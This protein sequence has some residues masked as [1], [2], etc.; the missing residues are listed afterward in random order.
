M[1]TST[2]ISIDKFAQAPFDSQIRVEAP[3]TEVFVSSGAFTLKNLSDNADIKLE[4]G[5]GEEIYSK[6][7][8]EML[9]KVVSNG[10][11]DLDRSSTSARPH[12]NLGL[13]LMNRGMLPEAEREL[14]EALKKDPKYFVAGMALARIRAIGGDFDGA[15]RL[16]DRLSKEH[17]DKAMPKMGLAYIAMQR[18]NFQEAEQ[19]LRAVVETDRQNIWAKYHLGLVL[20]KLE[21]SQ[22]AIALLRDAAR[23]GVRLPAIHHALGVAYAQKKDFKKAIRSFSMALSLA[24]RMRETIHAFSDVLLHLK[25]GE[26][27]IS[28]LR[29]FVE[30]EG[31]EVLET[32]EMLVRAYLDL[33]RHREARAELQKMWEVVKQKEDAPGKESARILS[34]IGFCFAV[35]K[36]K[37]AE[38]YFKRALHLC[39]DEPFF[40]TNLA[41]WYLSHGRDNEATDVLS[42]G[43]K[44]FPTNPDIRMLLAVSYEKVGS[45]DRA[46]RELVQL[47]GTDQPPAEAYA[48]LGFI[49]SAKRRDPKFAEDILRAGYAHYPHHIGIVNNYAYVLLAQGRVVTAKTVLES[50]PKQTDENVYLTATF[51]L[52]RLWEGDLTEG[53]LKYQ[54]AE[55]LAAR[56]G[57]AALA[58]TVRQKMHLELAKA[59]VRLGDTKAAA[60][61]V[62]KGL[63][64]KGSQIPLYREDL[65]GLASE[66]DSNPDVLPN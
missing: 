54:L 42:L 20:L 35:D 36:N 57:S 26:K 15:A 31:P 23:T 43:E 52:L 18:G 7:A 10:K 21:N 66:L 48:H 40:Y 16:Y 5:L 17:S 34:N 53:K 32:R 51:G 12:V 45:L 39:A 62:H 11:R 25:E 55:N 2:N 14:N 44:Q 56:S 22:N 50:L 19:L 63:M 58:R 33:G 28:L 46:I 3:A 60:V 8:D 61:E 64:V 6:N 37:E 13:S 47:I 24:P 59:F 4:E 41:R 27:A 65:E 30:Y 1:I 38:T 49:L 9:E 29:D